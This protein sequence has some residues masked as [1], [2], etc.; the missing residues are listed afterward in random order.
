MIV[1]THTEGELT[2]GILAAWRER[3]RER[4]SLA[5]GGEQTRRRREGT[6]TPAEGGEVKKRRQMRLG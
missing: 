4:E 3:E 6:V 5:G 2:G 1:T